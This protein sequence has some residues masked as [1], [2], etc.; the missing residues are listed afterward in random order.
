LVTAR[1]VVLDTTARQ[2]VVFDDS[3][4]SRLHIPT[5]TA[6]YRDLPIGPDIILVENHSYFNKKGVVV[7]SD[8]NGNIEVRPE[9]MARQLGLLSSGPPKMYPYVLSS[10]DE[11]LAIIS[12][13]CDFRTKMF[14]CELLKLGYKPIQ[15]NDIDFKT[16][17]K[18][19]DKIF[20]VGF[21]TES[22]IDTRIV[23][24]FEY[25]FYSNVGT[26]PM[27]ANGTISD[28]NP[29]APYFYSDIFNYHGF[30]GGA[31][32]K[33]N[34]LIGI[35]SGFTLSSKKATKPSLNDYIVYRAHFIKASVLLK[36]FQILDKKMASVYPNPK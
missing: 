1:H 36:Y 16:R 7:K 33:S 32:V 35:V 23:D 29:L 18:T 19:G 11:D 34:K 10:D 13:D 21:P 5:D 20:S 28:P 30:S 6:E 9:F 31:V 17:I 14:L 25:D 26:V 27:I 8:G 4:L 3:I 2:P 12:L 15:F 24:K 22:T